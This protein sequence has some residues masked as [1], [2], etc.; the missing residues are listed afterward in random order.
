VGRYIPCRDDYKIRRDIPALPFST[1]KAS[2][3]KA[4]GNQLVIDPKTLGDKIKK[5]RLDLGLLQKDA[6]AFLGVNEQNVYLWE[7]G[8]RHPLVAFYPKIINFLGYYPFEID[9]SAFGGRI[10]HYRYT[11]GMTPKQFGFLIPADASTVRGWENGR[12]VPPKRKR[13][14]VE[15]IINQVRT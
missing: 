5:R 3:I 8:H 2:S 13:L 10:T 12:L 6:A 1:L 11:L 15:R 4:T 7:N 9:L 14:I